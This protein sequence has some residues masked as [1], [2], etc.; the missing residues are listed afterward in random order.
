MSWRSSSRFRAVPD[1]CDYIGYFFDNLKNITWIFNY[2]PTGI[3][4]LKLILYRNFIWIM[5]IEWSSINILQ[6]I[7]YA[8][9]SL[10]CILQPLMKKFLRKYEGWKQTFGLDMYILVSF[11]GCINVWRG[12][13]MFLEEYSGIGENN[14]SPFI[15]FNFVLLLRMMSC[16]EFFRQIF[17]DRS[18]LAFG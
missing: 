17:V 16:V 7:G 14:V 4:T 3:F 18:S 11:C 15:L 9:T 1:L 8:S 6:G 2:P 12:I 5:S 10:T 13:W